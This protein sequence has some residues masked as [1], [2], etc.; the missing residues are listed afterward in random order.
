ME[1][2]AGTRASPPPP[3]PLHIPLCVCPTEAQGQPVGRCS[4]LEDDTSPGLQ[5]SIQR[6]DRMA[7]A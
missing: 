3:L 1:M 6:S 4:N 5:Q 7:L 2:G